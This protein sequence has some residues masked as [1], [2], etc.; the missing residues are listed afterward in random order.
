MQ[1]VRDRAV[2]TR[3]PRA[4]P[5]SPAQ[6][7]PVS[8]GYATY[9]LRV[10][11]PTNA[12]ATRRREAPKAQIALESPM[13]CAAP[14]RRA[15][16]KSRLRGPLAALEGGTT[17]GGGGMR[18]FLCQMADGVVRVECA[19]P[20]L[21]YSGL[22]TSQK[23]AAGLT[24]R[25]VNTKIRALI[26]S[27]TYGTTVRCRPSPCQHGRPTTTTREAL[28]APAKSRPSSLLAAR[29]RRHSG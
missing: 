29:T 28:G 13:Q 4:I 18:P 11:K 24:T 17:G 25:S 8:H 1:Q 20:S 23:A 16:P 10:Q 21:A 15:V 12:D 19:G 26:P 5:A 2:S 7:R 27:S 6:A 14:A 3:L 9:E 22:T